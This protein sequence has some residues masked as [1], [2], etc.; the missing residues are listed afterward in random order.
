MIFLKKNILND[1]YIQT[2]LVDNVTILEITNS[3][4]TPT[5]KLEP[6]CNSLDAG[7]AFHCSQFL[8]DR[9]MEKKETLG[10]KMEEVT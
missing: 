10:N 1:V 8:I 5:Q 2:C 6:P 9:Q 7:E 4:K 3:F